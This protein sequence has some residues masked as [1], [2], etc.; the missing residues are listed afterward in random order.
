MEPKDKAAEDLE[1]EG[2]IITSKTYTANTSISLTT[3]TKTTS[4][5]T[6]T[7]SEERRKINDREPKQQMNQI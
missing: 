7:M 6:S 4:T 2:T 1:P 3:A 5:T